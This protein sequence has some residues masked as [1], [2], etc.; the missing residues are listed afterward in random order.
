MRPDDAA[1]L[2]G[3]QA[4]AD[5]VLL[6][7]YVLYPYRSSSPK[8]Q[9]R[10]SFGVLAPESWTQAGGCEPSWMET[11]ILLQTSHDARLEVRLRFLH[12][13]RRQV[14]RATPNGGYE[15]VDALE[16]PGGELWVSWDEATVQHIDLGPLELHPH[17]ERTF[18]FDV[19]GGV[20]VD[21]LWTSDGAILGRA[22]R[23]RSRIRGV[24][25]LRVEA[26]VPAE[27]VARFGVARVRLRVENL[28]PWADV[29]S[30]RADI[31]P[32]SCVST[33]LLLTLRGGSFLSLLDPPPWA[34]TAARACENVGCYP[35][36]AGAPPRRDRM[37]VSPI[38]LYDYPQIAPESPGDFF[39]SS[40][41][42][43]LL[44]L[45]T[46]TLTPEEKR[47]VRA[48][49]PRAAALL[50]RV[51]AMPPEMLGRLHGAVREFAP[52]DA[53]AERRS[54]PRLGVGSRVRLVPGRRRTDAQ[55]LLYA[56]LVAT[57]EAVRQDIDGRDV[58]AVTIDQ[59]PAAELHRWYGRFH[60][61]YADEVEPL[62]GAP[63]ETERPGS[64]R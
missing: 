9:F 12:V 39:D 57:V 3:V 7:G 23:T 44:T 18:P 46:A 59:D 24:V 58:L 45:R 8:N 41:I 40:E 21:L 38:I 11:C 36:L 51:E 34:E 29:H 6:E 13:E 19:P 49:D 37:L 43:E 5:A 54:T 10:W 14:E 48:T 53:V 52:L 55:D 16:G 28:T 25:R 1:E 64:E 31:L 60:Y 61:Y 63:P 50:D 30:P 22:R 17:E 26:V 4:I 33:H 62:E 15:P 47:Q 35:V 27:K 56:G 2:D 32:A 20:D 42:D